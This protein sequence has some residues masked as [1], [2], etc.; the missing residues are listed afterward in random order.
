MTDDQAKKDS[1]HKT[2]MKKMKDNIDSTVAAADTE[3]GVFIL[4]TGNGK[5]KS[6]SAFG[7]VMRALGYGY[8]VGVVQFIKGAMLSGE[9]IYVR[10]QCPQVT[11]QQMGTGFTWDTQDRSA[12]IA[13]AEVSWAVAEK[14]LKDESYHLVVLDELTYM[15]SFKYLDE[16]KIFEALKNRPANQSVVVTGRGG[17][18]TL[19]D[20]A[21]TVSEIKEVKHAYNSGVMARK[22]VDY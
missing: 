11:F 9:E 5:G 10:D 14:M 8:K 1:S 6:S 18:S 7:M 13:A 21:D 2:K 20:M 19:A 4:L 17:G 22:G 15:L 3:R 16:N 12:D